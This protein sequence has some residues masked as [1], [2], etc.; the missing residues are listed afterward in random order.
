MTELIIIYRIVSLLSVVS[1][2]MERCIYYHIYSFVSKDIS[3][4]Q[5][6]F[7][8]RSSNAQLLK[9]YHD[10]FF[11]TDVIHLDFS[12]AFDSVS[13]SLLIHKLKTSDLMVSF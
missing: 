9:V 7:S 3:E 12:K 10:N 1:N 5:H 4:K 13:H 6:V 8:G 11:Q 2:I